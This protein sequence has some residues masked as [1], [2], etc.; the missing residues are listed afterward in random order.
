[1]S[2]S[3]ILVEFWL[4][5]TVRSI[6]PTPIFTLRAYQSIENGDWIVNSNF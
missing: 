5:R 2:F 1:M 6:I 4:L 3:I